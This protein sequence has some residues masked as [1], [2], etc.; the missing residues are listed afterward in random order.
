MVL[1]VVAK[2]CEKRPKIVVVTVLIITLILGS[3]ILRIE[4]ET[5]MMSYL[6]KEKESVE[7][8][9]EFRDTFGGQNY[10]TV[11]VKGEVTSPQAIEEIQELEEEIRAIP[12][13][14]LEVTSYIDILKDNNVPEERIP[15]AVKTPEAQKGLS[16][17]LTQ[18]G[19]ATLIRMRVS[20]DHE[21]GAVQEYID[22][23]E[24]AQRESSLDIS[25]TGELTQQTEMMDVMDRDN[26]V[27]LPAA[28]LLVIVVLF[29]TYRSISDIVLPFVIIGI[30]VT[31]VLGIMGYIG[32]TFSSMFVGVAPLLLGI[33]I[34]Y[35]VHML[36]RYYEERNKG[37]EAPKSA[38]ISVK[39]VGVA[40]LLTAVTTAFG[41][42]SF[43]ISDLPPMREFGFLLVL[44][45]LFSFFLV[46]TLMPSLLV[47]RDTG[48]TL[49][50]KQRRVSGVNYV[51]DKISLLALHHRKTVLATAGILAIIGVALLPTIPT[52]ISY[53]DMLPQDAETISTQSEISTLFG[54]QGEPL[55]VLVEGN[56]VEYYE[57][58]LALE[59]ELRTIGF[60][61]TEGKQIVMSISSYA[62]M[63]AKTQGD[64]QAALENPQTTSMI[65][66]TLVVD[67]KSSDY[68]KKGVILVY[69]NVKTDE[70]AKKITNEVREI[71][72]KNTTLDYS[73]GGGPALIADIMGGMQST[74][75]K[76]T[77]LAL[78]LSL[79]VVSLLFK[80]IPYG[81]FSVIPLALTIA[82]EFG[83]LKLASWHFD[84][85][86]VM[87]S[88][89][90]IGIGIDFSI[91]VIHRY[92]E[93]LEKTKN[94]EESVENT[95]L[96]VGKAL[97]SA[98]A[99]TAGA[100]FVLT[101]S[102]MPIMARFGLLVSIVICLSFLAALM[103][104][105]SILVFYS[106]DR[107]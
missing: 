104:L 60:T 73:V 93:E 98:T 76:T 30:A 61:N 36:N 1:D 57:E 95:V 35:T 101:F 53:E 88:A 56:V 6:P 59:E 54:A 41:F 29:L 63:L 84:L 49:Q 8:T 75:I 83:V 31:W 97:I 102:S 99:T 4:K 105:P 52:S 46:V 50:K 86:T 12:H 34:A 91:H 2:T 16:Q 18:D 21:E 40:V 66:Q 55:A 43:G 14:A 78:A 10:E 74:Q 3:G 89:L 23:L 48:S 11:L 71:L 103:V 79:L 33:A 62:D 13:F 68:L 70:D 85:F 37:Q 32:I 27:L 90:I 87:V 100:F 38:V 44:G 15:M 20:P 58:V 96:S 19:K 72:Q 5:D 64:V 67:K 24:N 65:Q 42:G 7:T 80:S 45:I 26:M 92:R 107:S 9:M 25:Y 22:V 51:L 81:I 94:T 77:L 69:V 28:L 17:I 47:L 106:K 82:W 39:T